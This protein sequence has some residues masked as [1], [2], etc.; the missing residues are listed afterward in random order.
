MPPIAYYLISLISVFVL[1]ALMT[2]HIIP[3][4]KSMKVGQ[5]ILDIGPRWHKNKENTPTMGGI[6]FLVTV[7]LACIVL[8]AVAYTEYSFEYILPLLLTLL[9]SLANGAIGIVDDMTKLKKKQNEGLTP[10][11]KIVLQVTFACAYIALMKIYGIIDTS[12]YIPYFNVWADLGF[13]YYFFAILVCLGTVNCVNLTDGIDGLASSVTMIVG[14]FFAVAAFKYD[15]I[16]PI[17]LAGAMSG[18]TL[19]FLV[20]NFYPARIFMGDTGSLFLGALVCGCA[21]MIKNP[22]II[23]LVGFVYAFE[24]LSVIL[25][26]SS[27]KLRHGKR[28][29]KM[30]PIHHH[31]E[32][33]GWSEIKIVSVASLVTAVLCA[34]AY[35]GL[36]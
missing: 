34:L 16:S 32:Q 14:A 9:F 20:Y 28:I 19:G 22:L 10:T 30:T 11:Q 8:G 25:Q 1:T 5:K 27:Y 18:V 17:I 7:T 36:Y 35:F 23:V 21:F 2:K 12:L 4:L 31:F 13:A 6:V 3:K 26:V 15:M 24:G 33:C 29:F